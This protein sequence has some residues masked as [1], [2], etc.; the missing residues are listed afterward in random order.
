M[1]T[2]LA[3][4]AAVLPFTSQA[5]AQTIFVPPVEVSTLTHQHF[6]DPGPPSSTITRDTVQFPCTGGACNGPGFT[7]TIG[8]GDTIAVRFEAPPGTRFVVTRA[9]GGTQYFWAIANWQT[10]TGDTISN[11][12]SASTT[13]ENLAGTAPTSTFEQHAV[14]DNGQAVKS[15]NQYTVSG[16]FSFT[17]MNVQFAVN[18]GVLSISRT[19]N[20]VDSIASPSFGS[21]RVVTGGASDTTV[22]SI[23]PLPGAPFCFGDGTAAAC[24]CGNS[25]SPGRG[26]QNS[27]TTGGA[28]LVATGTSSPDTM[29]LSATDEKPTALTIFLQGTQAISPVTYGD[30]LRC[31]HGVLKRLYTKTAAGGA[32]SAPQGGDLSITARS[33]QLSHPI[34]PG[35]TRYYM[36][37]YRDGAAGFCPSPTGSTFNGSNAWTILW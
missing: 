37:Y 23:E 24:P 36:T 3:I 10:N 13:F 32:A 4:A 35:S 15:L 19:Y 27:S 2:A 11:F 18:H 28:Q 14:S 21:A 22:M 8:M 9:P 29:V 25:G 7:A 1:R 17:A 20:P 12:A 26:C 31:V 6:A 5:G 34:A 30:G 33:A 16:S